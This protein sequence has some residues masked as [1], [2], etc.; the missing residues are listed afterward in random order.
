MYYSKVQHLKTK[1]LLQSATQKQN[2]EVR[3]HRKIQDNVGIKNIK[4]K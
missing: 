4:Q 2:R 3:S 1:N